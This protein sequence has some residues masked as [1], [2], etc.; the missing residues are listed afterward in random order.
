M[1]HLQLQCQFRQ[2]LYNDFRSH[3]HDSINLILR[4]GIGW[5]QDNMVATNTIHSTRAFI[6]RDSV[7]WLETLFLEVEGQASLGIE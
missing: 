7:F 1:C 4:H 2:N 6:Q 3:I 5:R